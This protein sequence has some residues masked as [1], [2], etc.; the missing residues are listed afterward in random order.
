MTELPVSVTGGEVNTDWSALR[1]N[2][3]ALRPATFAMAQPET[4][5]KVILRVGKRGL[6]ALQANEARE[7]AAQ[8]IRAA[9]T[10][11]QRGGDTPGNRDGSTEKR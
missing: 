6:V 3:S 8:L 9:H 10:I 1:R 4:P 2:S 11:E 5:R 7:L